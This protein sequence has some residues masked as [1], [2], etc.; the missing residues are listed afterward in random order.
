MATESLARLSGLE[1]SDR[2][3]RRQVHAVGEARL[4]ERDEAIEKL[5]SMPLPARRIGKP[6]EARPEVAVVWKP[7]LKTAPGSGLNRH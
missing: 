6:H 4:A 3:S 7:A 5:K 2:R 1:I